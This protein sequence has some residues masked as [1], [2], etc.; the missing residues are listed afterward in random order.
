[1]LGTCFFLFLEYNLFMTINIEIINNGAYDLLTS[2]ERLSLIRF[3]V[4]PKNIV[5]YNNKEKLSKKFAGSLKLSDDKYEKF[6]NTLQ[7]GR[8]E[9]VRDIY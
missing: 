1:M 8:S 7:E 4:L 9:W 2:M 5:N 6:Q 3:N